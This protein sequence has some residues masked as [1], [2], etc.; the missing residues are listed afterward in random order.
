MAAG[1]TLMGLGYAGYTV[2]PGALGSWVLTMVVYT[3][4]E[5]AMFTAWS[6]MIAASVDERRKASAF[7]LVAGMRGLG[8]AIGT[9]GGVWLV[10]HLGR[11]GNGVW[12]AGLLVAASS[13]LFLPVAKRA[14]GRNLSEESGGLAE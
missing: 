6:P 10:T 13:V 3:V 1:L 11:S 8:E 9:L 4:G 2:L 12:A 5:T 14:P 7:G